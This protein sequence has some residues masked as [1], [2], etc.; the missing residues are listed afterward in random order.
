MPSARRWFPRWRDSSYPE[1]RTRI[2]L[3]LF[4][5]TTVALAYVGAYQIL[6][7]FETPECCYYG[8]W[9]RIWLLVKVIIKLAMILLSFTMWYVP[10]LSWPIR[11]DLRECEQMNADK[12]EEIRRLTAELA[13]LRKS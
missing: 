13:T 11:D 12:A 5:W 3:N 2:I 7:S 4:M 8:F 6:H 1:R 9:D 10:M